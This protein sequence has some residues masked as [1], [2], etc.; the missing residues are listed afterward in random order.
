MNLKI[1]ANKI[2]DYNK[3]KNYES[4]KFRLKNYEKFNGLKVLKNYFDKIYGAQK[5]QHLS[6][7]VS[8]TIFSRSNPNLMLNCT[9]LIIREYFQSTNYHDKA[10]VRLFSKK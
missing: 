2:F 9:L 3:Q 8:A 1:I 10:F 6:K 7:N 5:I 4:E